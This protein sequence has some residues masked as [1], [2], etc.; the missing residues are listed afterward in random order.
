MPERRRP[1][2]SA[3][4]ITAKPAEL[5]SQV[6]AFVNYL[7]AECGMSKNT[8]AAYRT[9]L[10]QFSEWFRE[11]GPATVHNVDLGT[12]A[13]G[14]PIPSDHPEPLPLQIPV[15][16][17][18]ASRPACPVGSQ[19]PL[20]HHPLARPLP[21]PIARKVKCL[22]TTLVPT[23]GRNSHASRNRFLADTL[24]VYWGLFAA[25]GRLT[26]SSQAVR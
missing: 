12:P 23:A 5:S 19:L 8:L 24:R 2:S 14:P 20:G 21:Q 6:S 9:D 4:I 13:P 17:V 3:A 16:Q 10:L 1:V 15:R 7:Q 25:I 26:L 11:H 18:L 22:H